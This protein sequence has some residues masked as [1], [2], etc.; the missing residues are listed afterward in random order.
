MKNLDH[1]DHA[2]C[3]C[4]KLA[5]EVDVNRRRVLNTVATSLVAPIPFV[6]SQ[7]FAQ[8]SSLLLVDADALPA[9]RP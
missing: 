8:P 5:G 1:S 9:V 4:E 7:A 3:G 6:S 2:G